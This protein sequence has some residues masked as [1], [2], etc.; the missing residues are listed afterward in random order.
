MI[1]AKYGQDVDVS[2][3]L[4]QINNALD[5]F[6]VCQPCRTY[7]LSAGAAVVAAAA[8]GDEEADGQDQQA[9]NN[10]ADPNY[11]DFMCT[12]AAGNAGINMCEAI[13]K[14]SEIAA[15]SLTDVYLASS[16]GTIQRTFGTTDAYATWWENWGFLL[17]SYLTFTIG[18][19]CFCCV[20]VK[21]KRV[22]FSSGGNREPL[23]NRK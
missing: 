3:Q 5:T 18:V 20:A 17:S 2:A 7:D 4:Q 6:K 12:D 22:D 11:N 9:A 13:A 14:N 1:S 10:D 15:A 8:E 23:V 19:L 16:T 21:R